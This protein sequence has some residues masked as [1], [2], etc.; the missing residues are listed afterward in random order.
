MVVEFIL[1]E[2]WLE[3]IKLCYFCR[4]KTF[5][6]PTILRLLGF[7][8]FFY[9]NEG[10]EPVHVH[11]EKGDAQGKYWLEPVQEDYMDGFTKTEE[12]QVRKIIIDH[13]EKFITDWNEHF[14]G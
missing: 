2:F 5:S 6:M 13:Q 7:R 9:S 8:F 12:K 11:V 1:P 10:R 3:V 4:R 14:E